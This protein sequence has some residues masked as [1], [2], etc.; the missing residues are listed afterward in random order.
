MAML[1]QSMCVRLGVVTGQDLAQG[2]RKYFPTWF[3]MIL[4]VLCEIAIM[5]TDLAGYNQAYM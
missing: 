4:Y 3:A 5:A 1:L 2:C